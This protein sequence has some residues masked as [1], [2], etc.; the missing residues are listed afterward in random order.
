MTKSRIKTSE[1]ALLAMLTAILFVQE[2]LLSSLPNIQLS[3]VL[4]MVYAATLG[5]PKATLVM[6]LHV[7][8]DNMIWGSLN[9]LTAC[10][11]WLGWF[12]LILIGFALKKAPLPI[13]VTGSVIGSLIYCWCFALFNYL[14]MDINIVAYITADILFEILMCC[15]S[16]VTVMF[17]YRPAERLINKYYE[18]HINK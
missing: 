16:V 1:L 4:I 18:N 12:I 10:P 11:M 5:I 15:S 3:V 9:P 14:F 6:T 8:L 2:T 17:L 7:L 13:I